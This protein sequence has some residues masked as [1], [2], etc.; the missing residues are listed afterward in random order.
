MYLALRLALCRQSQSLTLESCLCPAP[1]MLNLWCCCPPAPQFMIVVLLVFTLT[2]PLLVVAFVH[3]HILV[4]T[5]QCQ[6]VENA[7]G[8]CAACSRLPVLQ[9][10]AAK[11]TATHPHAPLPCPTLLAHH[12]NLS[13]LPACHQAVF[14]TSI[15][16]GTYWGS[17]EVRCCECAQYA[18]C[19]HTRVRTWLSFV[20]CAYAAP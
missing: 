1:W 11:R 14:L 10:V 18:R 2:F 19:M 20:L 13:C 15:T 3:S 7:S 8:R 4:G 9:V 12:S 5:A 16:V 17:S 6:I